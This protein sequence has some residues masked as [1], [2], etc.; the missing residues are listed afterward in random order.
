MVQAVLQAT[1]HLRG[2]DVL[3]ASSPTLF[4]VVAALADLAAAAGAVRVRGARPVAG[5]LRRARRDPEPLRDL[6]ASSGSS[7]FLYRR[8][9]AVVTVTRAFADGHRAARDRPRPSSTSIPN[10]VDLEAF[11][12]EPARAGAARAARA[13]RRSCVVLYCGAHGISHA[14]GRIL[15]V[16][17]RLRG[18]PRIRFLFVGEG[19]EKE[20]LVA[21]ARELGLDNVT[22]PRQRAARGGAGALPQR[23]RVPGAAAR[24]AAVPLLHPVQDVRDPGLRPARPRV[25]RGR[26]RGDPAGLG[27]R[28]RGAAGG[29]GRARGGRSP[30]SPADPALRAELAARGR[31]YVAEHFDR[32]Q[33][34]APLSRGPGGRRAGRRGPRHYNRSLS[35]EP[36]VVDRPPRRSCTSWGP[37]RTS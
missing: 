31:P 5:D 35:E 27:R 11:Q 4:A 20:A 12:P 33:L 17:A 14:L 2:S 28:D 25:A 10:G 26:G 37:G 29:R 24:G 3:V 19:A 15:D 7:S 9:R 1:P 13:R 32:R 30:G 23:R 18:D 8:A 16:A 6:R 22:L 34:A 36:R 21:R